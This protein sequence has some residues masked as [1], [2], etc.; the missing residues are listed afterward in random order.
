MGS[1]SESSLSSAQPGNTIRGHQSPV[2][3]DQRLMEKVTR[4]RQVREVQVEVGQCHGSR[5]APVTRIVMDKTRMMPGSG[6]SGY[7]KLGTETSNWSS[8]SSRLNSSRNNAK[9]R[10]LLFTVFGWCFSILATF[11]IMFVLFLLAYLLYETMTKEAMRS[12]RVNRRMMPTSTPSSVLMTTLMMGE[13][14]IGAF[15]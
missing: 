3:S 10:P 7:T 5:H 15:D 1:Y 14:D 4:G 9:S 2:S 6:A 11:L 12:V 13:D 8:T